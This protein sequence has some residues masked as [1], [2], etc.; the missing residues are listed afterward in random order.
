MLSESTIMLTQQQPLLQSQ[1][2]ELINPFLHRHNDTFKSVDKALSN[3]MQFVQFMFLRTTSGRVRKST[4]RHLLLREL[5][6]HP[7]IRRWF[8]SMV[9]LWNRV[10]QHNQ[11]EGVEGSTQQNRLHG[12]YRSLLKAAMRDN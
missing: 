6:C 9:G 3:E 8:I 12:S 11:A 1:Q 2:S 5:G 7:L 4:S 10:A